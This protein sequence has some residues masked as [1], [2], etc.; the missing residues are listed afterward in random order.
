MHALAT[1]SP[2]L[3]HNL[4]RCMATHASTSSLYP[5]P[6][7][8]RPTAHAIFHFDEGAKPTRAQVKNR[9][10]ELVK[11][12]HPD[13]S[14][15]PPALA[16]ARFQAL[17]DAYD[18]L[19]GKRHPHPH[20]PQ[21]HQRPLTPEE[22]I[23]LERRRAYQR[24]KRADMNGAAG[25]KETPKVRPEVEWGE[26]VLLSLGTSSSHSHSPMASHA[27]ITTSRAR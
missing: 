3:A 17:A 4:A 5:W 20:S 24:A 6:K 27:T 25:K 1:R 21:Q 8:R 26:G 10:Y 13:T 9:Y 18:V 12:H 15:L 7:S 14:A 11:A 16:R 23:E 2:H 22:E 19:R